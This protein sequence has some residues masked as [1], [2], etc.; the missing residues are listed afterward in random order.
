MPTIYHPRNEVPWKATV[1]DEVLLKHATR[2]HVSDNTHLIVHPRHFT[3]DNNDTIKMYSIAGYNSCYVLVGGKNLEQS[4]WL[5]LG[6][7]DTTKL[8]YQ[9]LSSNEIIET[10]QTFVPIK[11][12]IYQ[13]F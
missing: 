8:L 7:I 2:Y 6:K 4:Q 13:A 5:H 10:I 9:Q 1:N 3:I 11:E 12:S